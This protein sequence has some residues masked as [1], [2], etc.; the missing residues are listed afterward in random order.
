MPWELVIWIISVVLLLALMTQ[1]WWQSRVPLWKRQ[2]RDTPWRWYLVGFPA[3]VARMRWTWRKLTQNRDL[4]VTRRPR[5]TVIGRDT[6]VRGTAVRPLPPRLGVPRPTPVGLTV[7]VHL[8]PG[9]TPAAF[10]A[11]ADAF[12]HAWRVHEV[13]VISVKRGQV[14]I[15][16]TATNP[17][18]ESATWRRV[19]APRLLA[20]VVGR[21][22]DSGGVWVIDFR[23]V[24]HWL[25]T[26]A[27]QSGKSTLLAA[28]VTELGAQD[29]ALV[30]VDC[31]GGLE[32]GVFER[33]LSALAT[34][35]AEAITVLSALVSE[36]ED[37]MAACRAA[38]VRSVWQLP[39]D[40]RRVPVV[41]V[42]DEVSELYLTDGSAASRKEAAECSTLL[43]RLAQLG[44]ALG[45]H[46]VVAAQ[47]FGSELGSGVTALRAQLGG[48]I[49]HRVHD[50]TTAEMTLGDL[51][52]DAVIV[53]QAIGEH[54]QGV[55]VTTVGGS[56]LRVRSRLLS[57]DQARQYA[58]RQ[59]HLTPKLPALARAMGEGGGS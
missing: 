42:V 56:W 21:T 23:S 2:A 33:R 35:R 32:L 46:V 25:I 9:Q 28:L 39:E 11:S 36:V 59:A 31:K 3:T 27:T 5:Y 1:G 55:A 19:P 15:T 40:E 43:L 12:A 37:R 10:I 24:P 17:L 38:G 44:A 48:R 41:L 54:E 13:R 50:E 52:P 34:T 29:V 30:G 58:E 51:S 57:P 14:L 16:A 45:V 8:H 49:C 47:R 20:A 7:R 6:M 26:G 22:G 18:I 4:A 53:A